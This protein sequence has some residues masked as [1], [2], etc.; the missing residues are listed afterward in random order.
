M[1]DRGRLAQSLTPKRAWTFTS[2]G[3][4]RRAARRVFSTLD[5]LNPPRGLGSAAVVALMIVAAGYGINRGGHAPQ[6]AKDLHALCDAAANVAGFRITSVAIAGAAKLSR[7][8]VLDLVGVDSGSSLLCLDPASARARLDDNPWVANAAVLK[9]YP[10]RLQIELTERRPVALWQKDREVSVI[11]ADGIVLEPYTGARFTEL[12]LVVGDGADREAKTILTLLAVAPAIR[13][14]VKASVLVAK[15][16]WNLHLK[17]GIEVLLP[18]EEP[19]AALALLAELAREKQLMSRDITLVDLRL[20]DRVTVRLSD[21]AAT[22]RAEAIA[23][24]L[25]DKKTKPGAKGSD[26]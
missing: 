3:R 5:D 20:P 4:W 14:E 12:P 16:R 21:A 26:T 1:D 10:G 9:L 17:N 13:A 25:K 6:L 15:R 11:A 2:K 24:A 18:E 23:A 22:A 19:G 8:E 7:G